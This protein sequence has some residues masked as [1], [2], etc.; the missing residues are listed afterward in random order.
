[1][2]LLGLGFGQKS[3]WEMGFGQNLGWEMGSITPF[4]TLILEL[5]QFSYG[6]L[7]TDSKVRTSHLVQ[8][9]K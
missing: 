6:I 7:F 3:D 1:M 2:S 5:A 4:R 9:N 8:P